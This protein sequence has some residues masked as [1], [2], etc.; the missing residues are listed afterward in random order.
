MRDIV[1]KAKDNNIPG[2]SMLILDA[3][4]IIDR[5]ESELN[6]KTIDRKTTK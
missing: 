1:K 5:D 6:T 3:I 2:D 4:W